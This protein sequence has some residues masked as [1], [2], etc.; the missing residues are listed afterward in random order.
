MKILNIF[1]KKLIRLKL[2]KVKS[3]DKDIIKLKNEIKN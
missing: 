1:V 3:Y 2:P